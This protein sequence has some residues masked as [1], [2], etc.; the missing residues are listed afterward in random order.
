MAPDSRRQKGIMF[1][2][3]PAGAGYADIVCL[4]KKDSIFPALVIELKRNRSA[5]RAIEQ[6]KDRR[7]PQAIRGYSGDIPEKQ[8]LRGT[9]KRYWGGKRLWELI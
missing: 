9:G 5:R 8:Y 3:L 7:H 6:M 1:Q 2:E 4:P